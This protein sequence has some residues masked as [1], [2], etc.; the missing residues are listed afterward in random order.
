MCTD[1]SKRMGTAS[2]MP[3][4]DQTRPSLNEAGRELVRALESALIEQALSRAKA[5]EDS[6][7]QRIAALEKKSQEAARSPEADRSVERQIVA[8]RES[9]ENESPQGDKSSSPKGEEHFLVAPI[10]GIDE[11]GRLILGDRRILSASALKI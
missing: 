8:L 9:L 7:E 6:L 4:R 3:Q 1:N 2:A 5:R 11:D 10:R